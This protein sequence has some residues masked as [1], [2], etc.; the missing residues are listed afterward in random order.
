MQEALG[1]RLDMSTAYHP[2]TDGQSERTIQTLEDMLRAC[3]LDFEE[4]PNGAHGLPPSDRLFVGPFEITKRIGRVAY[5]LRLLEELNGV[6]DT[7]YVSN[8][9][10][11]LANLTLQKL[12]RSR[13]AIVKVW[14]NSKRGPEFTW[15]RENQMK[16]KTSYRVDG[17]A[18][19]G[20]KTGGRTDRESGRTRGRTG[21]LGNGG[22]DEQGGQVG[23]Q[24]NK[25]NVRNIIVNNGRRGCS[26][27][28]FLACY[29]KEHDGKGGAIVYTRWIEKMESVHDMSGWGDD[30]KN[31]AMVGV[32]HAAYTDRFHEL[33]RL[34]PHLVT[35][36]NRRIERY[37]YGLDPQIEGRVATTK[38]M[39]IQKAVQTAGTLTDKAIRNGSLKKNLEKRWNGREP[40][41]DRN[42]KD[43]NKRTRTGNAFATTANSVR[44]EYTG[45]APKHLAKD[46]K[47]VPRMVNPVNTRNPTAADGACFEYGGTDH[48]NTACPRSWE[49]RQPGTWKGIYAGSRL[50]MT[51]TSLQLRVHEDDIPKTT[52]KTRYEHFKSTMMPFGLTNAP[53]TWEERKMHLGLVLELLKKEKLYAKFSKCKFSLQEV[54]FLGHVIN[55]LAGYYRRFIENF[56]MIAKSLTILT[57]KC[58]TFN[59]GCVLMQR[60]KAIAYASRQLKILKKNY[61]TQLGEANVVVDALSRKDG[62]KPK[63]IRGTNM[64]LQSSIKD[65][66]LSAQKDAFDEPTKMQRVLDD[67]PSGLLH[68]PEIPKRK[69]ERIAMDFGMKLP[70]T[71]SGHDA[72]WVIVDRLTKSAHFLPIRVVRFGK[73]EKLLLAPRFVGPFEITKRIGRVAYKLRLLEELN[74][75]HDTF[76]VSNLK[77]CLANPTLQ[78]PLDEIQV[79]AKLNFMEEPVEILEREFKK[80]K[81]S[82]IA[83]VKV[84]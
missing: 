59:W 34:V 19:R 60:G 58:K 3:V 20:R 25:G 1:T 2:Q 39:T 76:Y 65:K 64:T 81:R 36:K 7:F 74:G 68:Q 41:R 71:S 11:Y 15:E 33:A 53:A 75:V 35:P 28:E 73:K 24:G 18:P 9:K 79:D 52:F 49:Q 46:C 72:I 51:Q 50:T 26:Y 12:K 13:I 45:A 48:F 80:L 54:Q 83:I 32:G 16:L 44:R 63:R 6:H 21:D 40:S 84:R 82:R 47:V 55:G 43:D 17:A 69:W 78:L 30:Q 62:V 8:L 66:I 27:K 31:H 22:I 77:K 5:R 4:S 70:R 37:V 57:Q 38:L 14:W 29:P 56:S 61:T 67:W 42:V 23:G 10:K